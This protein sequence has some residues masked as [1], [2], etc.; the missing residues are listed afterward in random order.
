MQKI[1]IKFKTGEDLRFFQTLRQRVDAYFRDHQI[2]KNATP[3]MVI[4]TVILLGT[5]ILPFVAI[6]LWPMTLVPFLLLWLLMGWA[7]AGIGMNIMHDANHGAYSSNERVNKWIGWTLNLLGG[8]VANWKVQH[9]MLHHTYTN[10][11]GIDQDIDTMEIIR[12]TP[13]DP[14]HR[15]HKGQWWY[16]FFFYGIMTMY[17]T[18]AK[19]FVIFWS[20]RKKGLLKGLSASPAISYVR[21]VAVKLVYFFVFLVVP[22]LA[23]VAFIKVLAGFLLMHI[24]CGIILSVVFQLAHSVEGTEHPLPDD[25]GN[26]TDA[27]AVHQMRTTMN[28]ARHN[29]LLSW[30]IGGLNFQVEHHLFTRICHVHYPALAPIVKRTAEEF[31]VPYLEYASFRQ[32]LRSHIQLLRKL[33][34]TPLSEI[35]G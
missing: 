17:W 12:L 30:Y 24:T 7:K 21:V 3:G 33:G 31:G 20:Y 19:D 32:A 34:R 35:M 22:V 23:G 2:S 25:A 26:M 15:I 28:F 18:V 4:K 8:S 1:E 16:A 14:H 29:K 5:Y 6:L 27:W 9:N 11:I 13:H 10:I